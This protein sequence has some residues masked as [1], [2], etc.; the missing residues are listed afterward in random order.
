MHAVHRP[1]DSPCEL[2]ER[3]MTSQDGRYYTIGYSHQEEHL[4]NHSDSQEHNI[5]TP[6]FSNFPTSPNHGYLYMFRVYLTTSIAQD[7]TPPNFLH[8]H[9]VHKTVTQLHTRTA[10][11]KPSAGTLL[12]I[13]TRIAFIFHYTL[14]QEKYFKQ[15]S[16]SW[17]QNLNFIVP[18]F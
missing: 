17:F 12:L 15:N 9:G 13:I 2:L 7:Y 10:R 18:I 11:T 14:Q 5:P 8:Q 6:F 16:V 4:C 1:I 3:L